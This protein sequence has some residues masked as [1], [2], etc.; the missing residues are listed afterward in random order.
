MHELYCLMGYTIAYGRAIPPCVKR[1]RS[2]FLSRRNFETV[3][4]AFITTHLDYCNSLYYGVNSSSIGRLQLVQ[5]AAARLLT[6]RRKYDSIAPVLMSLRWLPVTFRIEFKILV[7]VYK[8]LHGLAPG[9]L[10]VLVL[11]HNPTRSLR[12]GDLGLLSVCRTR[13]KHRGDRAFARVGPKLW[14]SL[15][16]SIRMVSSLSLFKS[17]LKSYFLSKAFNN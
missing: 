7:F 15:P 11:P 6:G 14:N 9:Y 13:L 16:L 12:S 5:N 4:H 2:T 1:K 10:S 3:L 8:S 17:K